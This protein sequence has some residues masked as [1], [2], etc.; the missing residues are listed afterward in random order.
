VGEGAPLGV[1]ARV[2]GEDGDR[3]S[4]R[5]EAER[6]REPL[7][8]VLRA[9][10]RTLARRGEARRNELAVASIVNIRGDCGPAARAA[11]GQFLSSFLVTHPVPPGA[12]LEA[13]ARDVGRETARTKR[14]KLY[15]QT[16]LAL[17]ASGIFWR[18][19]SPERRARFHRRA[20][21]VW[22]GT[23]SLNVDALWAAA[24]G[25]TAVPDYVRAV[26]TGPLAP[27]V[28]AVT[29]AGGRLALGISY[30]T[31]AFTRAD[32][33]KIA[34]SIRDSIASLS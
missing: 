12:T 25:M 24:P 30:R 27:L 31:A 33:D 11:F 21:P 14:E 26:P 15:L 20:Y 22:A 8:P 17:A 18:L 5:G 13:L 23:T 4:R 28:V 6:G 3:Q 32:M 10:A 29:T 7:V 1:L 16:L 2:E 34:A 9:H 19:L